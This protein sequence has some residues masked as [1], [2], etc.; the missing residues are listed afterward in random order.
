MKLGEN[1]NLRR[2]ECIDMTDADTRMICLQKRIKFRSKKRR[3]SIQT[4]N[5]RFESRKKE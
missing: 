5:Q 1:Q 4:I 3:N 2:W